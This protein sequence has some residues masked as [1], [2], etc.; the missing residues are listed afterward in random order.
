MVRS[1]VAAAVC[2]VLAAC[3]GSESEPCTVE[4]TA[5][6][7]VITC[8]DGTEATVNDGAD[9]EDG[10]NGTNG[11]P[12]AANRIVATHFCQG[13]LEATAL[14]F[15]YS[16]ALTAAGDVFV[17]ASI[18]DALIEVPGVAYFAAGQAGAATA[19]AI[20]AYDQAA[21]VNGGWWR[22]EMNRST[23]VVTITYNDV[24]VSGGSDS[25][26]MLPAACIT[27]TF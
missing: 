22:I 18:Q 9:G 2:L 15:T 5:S 3:G 24:D 1:S 8:P 27:N 6:G 13:A 19:P 17:D 12:G 23:L 16:A 21:P 10:T 11:A 4:D 20:F 25:W 7:A 14:R 26:T